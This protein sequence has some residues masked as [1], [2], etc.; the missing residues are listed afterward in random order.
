MD[1]IPLPEIASEKELKDLEYCKFHVEG[2]FDHSREI[3]IRPRTIVTRKADS[4]GGSLISS[5]PRVG[6]HVITPFYIPER[7]YSILINRGYVDENCINPAARES[8]Q[9]AGTVS[10][11]GIFRITEKGAMIPSND[12]QKSVWRSVNVEEMAQ[13]TGCRPILLE[14]AADS[15]VRG[16]P[17][18][19]QTRIRLRDQ[20]FSYIVTWYSIS[21]V[22][23]V[24]WLTK[25]VF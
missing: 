12:P 20:H 1:P 24:M 5:S 16:G 23:A 10:I 7:G 3:Y 19:G 13:V 2:E 14:A 22:T 8:G 25:Y 6:A 15:T 9:V 17:I 11:N 18:G 4:D 21:A